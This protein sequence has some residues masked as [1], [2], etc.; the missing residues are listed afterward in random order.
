[1]LHFISV[2]V[3]SVLSCWNGREIRLIK[4]LIF[5]FNNMVDDASTNK[6]KSN[7]SFED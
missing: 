3:N 2:H 7:F 1:M 5:D 6:N 4:V